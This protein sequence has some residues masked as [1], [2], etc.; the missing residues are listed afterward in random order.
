GSELAT[1]ITKLG[2]IPR[3]APAVREVPCRDRGPA[4]AA[5]ERI[6]RGE[7]PVILFL[8]GVG[9]RAFLDLAAEPGRRDDLG[10]ALAGMLVAARGPK[11][12]TV[13]RA[14]AIRIDL[15]PSAPTSEALL[16]ALKATR[17]LQGAL[18]A[19]QL[20]GDDRTV[21]ERLAS[22]GAEPLP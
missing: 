22:L 1:L 19:V 11:P 16:D 9:T 4:L 17:P 21:V 10:R 20:F 8:T 7:V 15:I 13:L 3:C 5:L 18:V 12:V 6:C 2:G 14:A